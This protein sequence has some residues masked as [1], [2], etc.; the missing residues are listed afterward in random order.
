MLVRLVREPP[1]QVFSFRCILAGYLTDFAKS[2]ISIYGQTQ[3]LVSQ[4]QESC[5]SNEDP[6]G[7]PAPL[8]C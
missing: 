4:H 6:A 3:L 7:H 5:I 1:D 2:R 8:N